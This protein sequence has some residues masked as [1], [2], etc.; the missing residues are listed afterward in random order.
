MAPQ[1]EEGAGAKGRGFHQS[2]EQPGLETHPRSPPQRQALH[3]GIMEGKEA[4]G[5]NHTG[6]RVV[7]GDEISERE[8]L[9]KV[10]GVKGERF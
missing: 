3:L 10:V 1:V 6:E 8:A 9:R 5:Q 4:Q 2:R 7:G